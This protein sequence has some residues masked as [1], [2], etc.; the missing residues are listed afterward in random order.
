MS[1]KNKQVYNGSLEDILAKGY[2]KCGACKA[3]T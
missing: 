1:D 2:Q 3:G